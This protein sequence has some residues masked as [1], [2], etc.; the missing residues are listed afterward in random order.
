MLCYNIAIMS[1]D[2]SH[3]HHHGHGHS[4]GRVAHAPAWSLLRLSALERL[5]LAGGL[6]A[7]LWLAVIAVML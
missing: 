2:H 7:L 1:Q 4:H 6:V 3:H 5:G